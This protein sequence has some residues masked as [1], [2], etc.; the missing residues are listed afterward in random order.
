MLCCCRA[1]RK[2]SREFWSYRT[3]FCLCTNYLISGAW[4]SRP[5]F[6]LQM[7]SAWILEGA[8][9]GPQAVCV[10]TASS[11]L[12][13]LPEVWL[14]KKIESSL[15]CGF[16]MHLEMLLW[17]FLLLRDAAWF[18]DWVQVKMWI[19]PEWS[20]GE[21]VALGGEVALQ[22]LLE[23]SMDSWVHSEWSNLNK[24]S[25]KRCRRTCV[26]PCLSECL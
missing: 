13:W 5:L 19:I 14:L 2:T 18:K 23:L 26:L 21:S 16:L 24:S 1:S 12:R 9:R 15:K 6:L 22:T 7:L 25:V 10:R 4:T 3:E 20:S 11:R 8:I 17:P